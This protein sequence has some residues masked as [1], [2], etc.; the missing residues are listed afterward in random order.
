MRAVC[1]T[2]VRFDVGRGCTVRPDVAA[3]SGLCGGVGGGQGVVAHDDP[4]HGDAGGGVVDNP[5]AERIEHRAQRGFGRSAQSVRV[6][7][8]DPV[9][10]RKGRAAVRRV[11]LGCEQ[12]QSCPV[13][14]PLRVKLAYA[15][16]DQIEHAPV[17]VV[18]VLKLSDETRLLLVALRYGAPQ[19]RDLAVRAHNL[20]NAAE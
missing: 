3:L 20:R 8:C 15:P 9:D 13:P 4:T 10:K 17:R 2:G 1:V 14:F 5:Q 12:S 6:G 19:G 11:G 18:A 7:G 16:T